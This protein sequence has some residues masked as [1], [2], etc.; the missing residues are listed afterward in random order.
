MSYII[1][2]ILDFVLPPL[3]PIT[4][5]RVEEAGLISA[6]AWEGLEF[7]ETPFCHQCGMPQEF[8]EDTSAKAGADLLCAICLNNPP[9]YDVMRAVWRYNDDTARLI[10]RFK[11]GDQLHLVR[12]F[13]P[14]LKRAVHDLPTQ[15]SIIVPVPLHPMRL[16]K[17][18]YNQAG[19][20]AQALSKELPHLHYEP[21]ILRRHK[22]TKSQ[23]FM[24]HE[25]RRQ[26]VGNAF[27]L[28]PNAIA[29][30]KDKHVLLIDDV[31][32]SGA[33]VNAC[34]KILKNKGQAARVDV[35]TLAR[36]VKY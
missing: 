1:K 2:N 35:I 14:H 12:S 33:T 32:T 4:G 5:L 30:L 36:V 22:H 15:H 13:L 7:I 8:I 24:K 34:A 6:E 20:L 11:H 27:S 18:L 16:L 29:T 10:M 25:A 23:G 9:S 31:Y 17:R 3:C 28:A 21:D 19:L 26:N